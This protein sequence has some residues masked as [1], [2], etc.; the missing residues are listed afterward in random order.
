LPLD[1]L[2]KGVENL[3]LNFQHFFL[4]VFHRRHIKASKTLVKLIVT[5]QA[6]ESSSPH[7][8]PT[9]QSSI[10][11]SLK[12]ARKFASSSDNKKNFD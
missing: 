12:L 2:G 3:K 8:Y 5:L 6:D 11:Q 7:L 4:V 9:K 10:K 1:L